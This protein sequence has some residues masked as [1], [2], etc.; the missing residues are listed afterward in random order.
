[1]WWLTFIINTGWF[2]VD[3]DNNLDTIND[4]LYTNLNNI[5]TIFNQ[6]MG[7]LFDIFLS[8]IPQWNA[9]WSDIM[10]T[11]QMNIPQSFFLEILDSHIYN[12]FNFINYGNETTDDNNNT[13]WHCDR[14]IELEKVVLFNGIYK[15]IFKHSISITPEKQRRGQRN[16]PII[17]TK[18]TRVLSSLKSGISSRESR[19]SRE[20]RE[21]REEAKGYLGGDYTKK[22]KAIKRN[23]KKYSIRKK[24]K[25]TKKR[26]IKKRKNTKRL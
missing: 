22:K 13:F 15:N 24:H 20:S 14:F 19:K 12:L 6:N 2:Y 23:N 4:N 3:L 1:M 21:S 10:N 5:E 18:R 8:D 7:Q 26:H 16:A 17:K 25:K 9:Q 11:L